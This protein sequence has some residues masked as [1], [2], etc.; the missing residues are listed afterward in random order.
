MFFFNSEYDNVTCL[1]IQTFYR[2][3]LYTDVFAIINPVLGYK[4]FHVDILKELSHKILSY[5]WRCT[6]NLLRAKET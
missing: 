1:A 5:F 4:C 6:N 3:K 2:D